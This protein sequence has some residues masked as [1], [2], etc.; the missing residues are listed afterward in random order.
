MIIYLIGYYII[1]I[2]VFYCVE[3]NKPNKK[4]KEKTFIEEYLK[5]GYVIITK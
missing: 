5:N 3:Y 4:K 1:S 2:L